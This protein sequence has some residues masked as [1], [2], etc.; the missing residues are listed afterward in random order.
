MATYKGSGKWVK[1]DKGIIST[2]NGGYT[3]TSGYAYSL[4][5]GDKTYYG[6]HDATIQYLYILTNKAYI[7]HAQGHTG[8]V[9]VYTSYTNP[10]NQVIH[11][12][13]DPIDSNNIHYN[14][15]VLHFECGILTE[16][17]AGSG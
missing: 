3:Y 13:D 5:Y 12:P 2:G 10:Y 11:D 1:L 14:Y 15:Y 6:V 8:N 4:D 9:I 17:T 16:V 7:S